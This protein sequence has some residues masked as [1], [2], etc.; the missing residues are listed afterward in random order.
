[1]LDYT[2]ASA[3]LSFSISSKTLDT[4]F[5]NTAVASSYLPAIPFSSS[6][7]DVCAYLFHASELW[8]MSFREA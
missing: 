7:R 1:V 4:A 8:A 2:S 5:W 6:D 3:Y